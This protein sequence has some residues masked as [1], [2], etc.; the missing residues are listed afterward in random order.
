[1]IQFLAR[2]LCWFHLFY[3]GVLLPFQAFCARKRFVDRGQIPDRVRHFRSVAAALVVYALLSL[4]TAHQKRIT[5]FPQAVP[6]PAAILAGLAMYVSAVAFMFPRW[7]AAVESRSPGVDLFMPT[8]GVERAWWLSV[9]VLAGISEEIT[10]RCVQVALLTQL[11]GDYRIAAAASAVSFACAHWVQG[12]RSVA[13]ILLF[14][15]GF[16]GLVWLAGSIY[17]AI[18]VHIAYDIT[19]GIAYGRLGRQLDYPKPPA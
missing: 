16:Q 2:F 5:V 10:W 19:A 8:S 13:V 7:R 1:M 12:P 6:A 15:G 11:I 3:F 17:V 18:V 14:A 4:L 9:S